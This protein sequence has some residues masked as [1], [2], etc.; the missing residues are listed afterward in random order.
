[1]H[2]ITLSRNSGKFEL[3]R[4][5]DGKTISDA[6]THDSIFYA[7]AYHMAQQQHHATGHLWRAAEEA[8]AGLVELHKEARPQPHVKG[9]ALHVATVNNYTILEVHPQQ[10][11]P[12]EPKPAPVYTCSCDF[13]TKAN[14]KRPIIGGMPICKHVLAG[15]MVRQLELQPD[16]WQRK[17]AKLLR[18]RDT[19]GEIQ[20]REQ[21][22]EKMH[23]GLILSNA[24]G[25]AR[26][27]RFNE[28]RRQ[29]EAGRYQVPAAIAEQE[30]PF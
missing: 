20:K 10:E 19:F 25:K 18:S 3:V 22:A 24:K 1:M 28:L 5:R 23:D 2:K 29:Q 9:F 16:H 6:P 7:M 30:Q 14:G 11:A 26:R 27:A 13:Y 21:E 15:M 8:A 17:A 12:S 4:N